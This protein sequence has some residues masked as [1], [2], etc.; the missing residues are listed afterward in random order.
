MG[1]ERDARE[2]GV[3][4]S[5]YH[6]INPQ[7]EPCQS[8][9]NCSREA[10]DDAL[11]VRKTPWGP[12]NPKTLPPNNYMSRASPVQS[13]YEK[14]LMALSSWVSSATRAN[15]ASFSLLSTGSLCLT[16]EMIRQL[17]E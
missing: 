17:E 4:L 14:N 12:H 15:L 3:L 7:C 9:L 11:I 2:L 10:P 13:A 16:C 8:R 6:H 5:P 1:V